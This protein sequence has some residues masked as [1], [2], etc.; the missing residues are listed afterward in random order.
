MYARIQ[1]HFALCDPLSTFGDHVLESGLM[2]GCF[3]CLHQGRQRQ[4]WG[5]SG[6]WLARIAL[7]HPV[8]FAHLGS[9]IDG[10][11]LSERISVTEGK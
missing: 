5:S 1:L 9:G 7:A 4:E 10:N 8:G 6:T 3:F 2:N 11:E